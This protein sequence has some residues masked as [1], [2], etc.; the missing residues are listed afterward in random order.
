MRYSKDKLRSDGEQTKECLYTMRR[1]M[2][3]L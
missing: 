2:S 1:F 3:H